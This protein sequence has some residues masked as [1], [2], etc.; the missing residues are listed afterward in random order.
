MFTHEEIKIICTFLFIG[1]TFTFLVELLIRSI[2]ETFTFMERFW[3][4]FVW[5]LF[6]LMVIYYFFKELF[7]VDND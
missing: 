2:N 5:P 1:L 6:I 7:N 3:C 4:V